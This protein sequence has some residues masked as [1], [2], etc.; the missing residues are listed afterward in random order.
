MIHSAVKKKITYTLTLLQAQLCTGN[1]KAKIFEN[2]DRCLGTEATSGT[3]SKPGGTYQLLL[4]ACLPTAES[5]IRKD[6]S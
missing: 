4:K 5:T 2:C 3:H 6:K 1:N